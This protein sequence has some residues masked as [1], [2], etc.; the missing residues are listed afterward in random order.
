MNNELFYSM[1]ILANGRRENKP[2][3]RKLQVLRNPGKNR[4]AMSASEATMHRLL[5]LL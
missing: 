1:F 2:R 3:G 4:P 5:V